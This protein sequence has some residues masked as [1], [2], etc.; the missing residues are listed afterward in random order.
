LTQNLILSIKVGSFFLGNLMRAPA[1]TLAVPF[2]LPGPSVFT[3]TIPLEQL[4]GRKQGSSDGQERAVGTPLTL[5]GP[6]WWQIACGDWY[7][8]RG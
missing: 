6:R 2:V 3:Q 5:L 7:S 4:R 1:L 8:Y